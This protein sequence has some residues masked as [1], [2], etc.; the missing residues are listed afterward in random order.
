M[1]ATIPPVPR[2]DIDQAYRNGAWRPKARHVIERQIV[3]AVL[4]NLA[5]EFPDGGFVVY[6]GGEYVRC[7]DPK[8]AMEAIF[9]VDDAVVRIGRQWVQLVLGNGED[10]VADYGVNPKVES[11]IN[12]AMAAVGLN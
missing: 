1:N 10:V 4:H 7:V 11:A 6:D 9:A 8:A 5:A 12:A 3:W 2:L